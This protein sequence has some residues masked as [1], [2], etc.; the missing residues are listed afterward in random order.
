[1]AEGHALD[2]AAS[3]T[4]TLSLFIAA[5]AAT[6]AVTTPRYV[7]CLQVYTQV[8]VCSA[9]HGTGVGTATRRACYEIVFARHSRIVDV[10]IASVC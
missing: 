9:Q 8:L 3:N 1:M 4:V 10:L 6:H 5:I 7:G 2:T